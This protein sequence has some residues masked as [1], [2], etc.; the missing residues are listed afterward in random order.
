M[1]KQR[2]FLAAVVITALV[3]HACTMPN[4]IEIK[5]DDL[6]VSLPVRV[7]SFNIAKMISEQ[8][9]DSFPDGF[10]IY[11]MIHYPGSK[12]FLVAY[13]M[14]LLESFD[15]GD[16]LDEI[17]DKINDVSGMDAGVLRDISLADA[18][19]I[20]KIDPVSIKQTALVEV[21]SLFSDVE[22]QLKA[23]NIPVQGGLTVIAVPGDFSLDDLEDLGN[24]PPFMQWTDSSDPTAPQ[25]NSV[26]VNSGEIQLIFSLTTA[27]LD[28][29]ISIK[30][31]GIKLKVGTEEITASPS[32]VVLDSGNSARTVTIDL[33]NTEISRDNPPQI[34]IGGVA[35]TNG[36]GTPITANLTIQPSLTNIK[37]RGV[38]GL[39]LGKPIEVVVDIDDP[40]SIGVPDDFLN[41]VIGAGS[42]L[43]IGVDLPQKSVDHNLVPKTYCEGLSVQYEITIRQPPEDTLPYTFDNKP[44]Y[45]LSGPDGR[46]EINNNPASQILA[47]KSVNGKTVTIDPIKITVM[48]ESGGAGADFEIIDD[49]EPSVSLSIDMNIDKL[50]TVRWRLKDG[51]DETI[52]I[53]PIEIPFDD[54]SIANYVKSITLEEIVMGLD[55]TVTGSAPSEVIGSVGLGGCGLPEFLQGRIALEVDCPEL[56]FDQFTK[57]L[58]TGASP[59]PYEII[60]SNNKPPKTIELDSPVEVELSVVPVF[61]GEARRDINYIEFGPLDIGS[62][63]GISLYAKPS[64]EKIEWENAVIKL[65]NAMT[66]TDLDDIDGT[67]PEEDEEGVNLYDN[68]GRHMKGITLSKNIQT[69]IFFAGPHQ[70]IDSMQLGLTFGAKWQEMTDPYG[71][72]K[73]ENWTS[74]GEDFFTGALNVSDDLPDLQVNNYIYNRTGMPGSPGE[75][76]AFNNNFTEAILSFPKDLRFTYSMD[77]KETITVERE[78]FNNIS[79]TGKGLKAM[80]VMIVPLELEIAEN[81]LYSLTVDMFSDEDGTPSEDLFG[82]KS[83]DEDS[84]FTNIN[85]KSLS[86]TIDFDEAFLWGAPGA[87]LYLGSYEDKD[88][89]KI[90]NFPAGGFPLDTGSRIGITLNGNDWKAVRDNLIEPMIEIRFPNASTIKVPKKI[91][92]TTITL[93]A[94]GSYTLGLD[95]MEFGL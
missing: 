25:F 27:G 62:G 13:T 92:P 49:D 28:P 35:T 75:G 79:E 83:T 39:K 16:Y 64:V 19:K 76:M 87:R 4:S 44:F 5:A 8:F 46:W 78:M 33:N 6:K 52:A 88:S 53:L 81:S 18:I 93:E 26:V 17:Q 59:G 65:K 94:S 63:A 90:E 67:F 58:K 74:K 20:P 82:R 40:I 51:D 29:S 80:F 89:L 21:G 36:T 9:A 30:L 11:D 60:F 7:D 91:I 45:G 72:D 34:I 48:T 10:E 1:G 14:D 42:L 95:S 57:I 43:T 32:E 22:N 69:K 24:L 37:L 86:I 38:K 61:N 31:S 56:G 66:D 41:A 85:V 3:V 68:M 2:A 70:L 73:P 23:L 50:E 77:M 54:P 12:A 55:F 15:P 84:I 71:E 47:G